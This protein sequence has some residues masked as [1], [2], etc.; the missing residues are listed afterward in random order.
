MTDTLF[1]GVIEPH[2]YVQITPNNGAITTLSGE[3]VASLPPCSAADATRYGDIVISKGNIVHWL[4]FDAN[5]GELVKVA[6][7]KFHHP[8]WSVKFADAG[9][10]ILSFK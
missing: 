2:F 5:T 7:Q 9:K 1:A 6:E 8:V 10:N 3:V 4:R